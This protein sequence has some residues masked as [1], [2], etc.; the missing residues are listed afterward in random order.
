MMAT[1]RID[2]L[3]LS[4]FLVATA[5]PAGAQPE[6]DGDLASSAREI[7]RQALLVDTHIDMPYRL[8]EGWAD[9]TGAA[10]DRDF[11][12]KRA[13]F[14]GLDV[15]FMSIYTPA[16]MEETGGAYLLANQLI[17]NVE[18]LVGRA[19]GRFAMAHSTSEV[20][21]A[22]SSGLIALAL[23]L[24]NGS[25]IEGDLGNLRHFHQRGIRY[26]TLAHSL[27][28]HIS[29]S[30]YDEQ[31]NWRGL[32]PFG[33]RVVGEMNRL[34]IM[35]DVSHVSDEAFYDV[36]KITVAPV[37]A[38]HSSAR[39]FTPGWERNMSDDMIRAL[40]ENGGVIMINFGSTFLTQSAREWQTAMS[41]MRDAWLAE[42]GLDEDS[43]EASDWQ[44]NYRKDNPFPFATVADV[45]D[46][47]D[48]VIG[49]VGVGHVGIGSD[50]DGLGDS[51]PEGLK[52][53]STYPALV[54][55][56]LRRGY[57]REEIEAILGGNLMR[58]WRAV[59]AHAAPSE[60]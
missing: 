28:N 30:S 54:L 52:D 23:G 16:K 46:H 31:R 41:E 29:D 33:E 59:E 57:A 27:S 8:Q 25:P 50:Y 11:D 48:H 34:G 9:V 47:F 38:S 35:I 53:V 32:S 7:A 15:P 3:F 19:P 36:L 42:N 51:L 6:N 45:A 10:P 26:I 56:F 4:L 5:L 43:P 20:E 21:A 2:F 18:A 12:Y 49:L 24:E 40:A 55:E 22:R 17:D 13:K 39:H 44:E 60:R 1:K 37:I 58:V 14:G